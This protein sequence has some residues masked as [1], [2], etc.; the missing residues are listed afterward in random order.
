MYTFL[1]LF[2]TCLLGKVTSRL[3]VLTFVLMGV[4]FSC[5]DQSEL[6]E[7]SAEI[8]QL[9]I[10]Q[11]DQSLIQ[12]VKQYFNQNMDLADSGTMGISKRQS[13]KKYPLWSNAYVYNSKKTGRTVIVPLDYEEPLYVS[14]DGS[15]ERVSLSELTNLYIYQDAKGQIRSEVVTRL[16]ELASWKNSKDQ[17]QGKVFIES[18]E[19]QFI[20]GYASDKDKTQVLVME[21]KATQK[22]TVTCYTTFFYSC[23]YSSGEL[24]SCQQYDSETNCVIDVIDGQLPPID[25]IDDGNGG[26]GGGVSNP[27]RNKL[28]GDY[29]FTQVYSSS[30]MNI[31][32]LG[33]LYT[34]PQT[35]QKF[36]VNISRTCVT[37]TETNILSQQGAVKFASDKFKAAWN[38]ADITV[39]NELKDNDLEADPSKVT[40]RLLQLINENLAG[41]FTNSGSSIKIGVC[42]ENVNGATAKYCK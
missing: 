42:N 17:Y 22:S 15:D 41:S 6:P 24:I 30:M 31:Y 34:N 26:G 23:A 35:G 27:K 29:N 21:N 37:I 14:I 16:P 39:I 8:F 10:G 33:G 13:I 19:G 32:D 11:D 9:E 20:K 12:Y 25:F 40:E 5:Q 3:T 18:W 7:P 36:G 4:L 1:N 38:L 28:C 2:Y